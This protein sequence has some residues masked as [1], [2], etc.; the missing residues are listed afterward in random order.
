MLVIVI[1]VEVPGVGLERLELLYPLLE[2]DL[3]NGIREAGAAGPTAVLRPLELEA[4]GPE[5]RD[6]LGVELRGRTLFK[7]CVYISNVSGDDANDKYQC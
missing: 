1:D 6:A 3:G 7:C 5:L 2:W 4:N